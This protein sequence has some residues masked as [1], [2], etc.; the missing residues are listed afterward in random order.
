MRCREFYCDA[1][2]AGSRLIEKSKHVAKHVKRIHMLRLILMRHAESEWSRSGQ[3]D[4]ER[5][6]TMQGHQDVSQMASWLEG[7]SFIP[8]LI[9][10]SSARRTKETATDLMKAL[11]GSTMISYTKQLYLADPEAIQRTVRQ[12]G[13]DFQNLMVLAHN[14]GL[15]YLASVLSGK[16]IQLPT[17]GL[18]LFEVPFLN[19]G[20]FKLSDTIRMVEFMG[21]GDL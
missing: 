2:A 6:L 14:P 1:E 21:P 15:S 4:H 20:D 3:N 9:L 17:A 16:M 5:S 7:K 13:C 18:V 12:D 10:C 11:G 8:G 19:W